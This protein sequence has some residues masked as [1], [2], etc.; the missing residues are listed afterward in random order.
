MY[1]T[2]WPEPVVGSGHFLGKSVKWEV[3]SCGGERLAARKK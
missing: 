2:E 3:T 1:L